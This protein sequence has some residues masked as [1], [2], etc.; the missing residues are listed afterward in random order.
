M[1]KRASDL[2]KIND[3]PSVRTAGLCTVVTVPTY[4]A[5]MFTTVLLTIAFEMNPP[6]TSL[7]RFGRAETL[8][9]VLWVSA[10]ISWYLAAPL[11]RRDTWFQSSYKGIMNLALLDG[12]MHF[13]N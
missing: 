12:V 6:I 4:F 11:L 3:N 7:S 10:A 1:L 5:C 13:M 8:C 2:L 9:L